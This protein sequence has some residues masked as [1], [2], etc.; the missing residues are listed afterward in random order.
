MF[1][2]IVHGN[3]NISENRRCDE[4]ILLKLRKNHMYGIITIFE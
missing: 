4:I 1:S 3:L 2:P